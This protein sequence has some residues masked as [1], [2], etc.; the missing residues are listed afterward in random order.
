MKS[1]FKIILSCAL[2]AA[3]LM[4]SSVLYTAQAYFTDKSVGWTCT[5]RLPNTSYQMAAS[6]DDGSSIHTFDFTDENSDEEIINYTL[7]IKN[8][9][10]VDMQY[11]YNTDISG[12]VTNKTVTV[13]AGKEVSLNMEHAVNKEDY[14]IGDASN[15]EV[16]AEITITP[17]AII[18]EGTTYPISGDEKTAV[19]YFNSLHK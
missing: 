17:Y 5:Y 19:L 3:T 10:N 2:C 15:Y 14:N 9:G 16:F 6:F 1:K 4:A 8:T 18:D 13:K 12:E 7:K 11:K